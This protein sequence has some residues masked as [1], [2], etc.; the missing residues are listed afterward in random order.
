MANVIPTVRVLQVIQVAPTDFVWVYEDAP[1]Q[2]YSPHFTSKELAEAWLFVP[3]C[4]TTP[5][6]PAKTV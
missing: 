3:V 4:V 5:D 1:S 6:P 2:E